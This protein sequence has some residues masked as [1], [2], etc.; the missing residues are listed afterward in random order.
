MKLNGLNGVII[1]PSGKDMHIR[2]RVK[3]LLSFCLGIHYKCAVQ[4]NYALKPHVLCSCIRIIIIRYD[5]IYFWIEFRITPTTP[6]TF[7]LLI[8]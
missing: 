4:G 8:V 3:F 5:D 2:V 1:R 7:L 6:F